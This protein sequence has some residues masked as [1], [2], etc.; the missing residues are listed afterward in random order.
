M[1]TSVKESPAPVAQAGSGSRRNDNWLFW[2]QLWI[3]L[4][5]GVATLVFWLLLP[6]DH[7]I[8]FSERSWRSI[9]PSFLDF[10]QISPVSALPF[11]VNSVMYVSLFATVI[12]ILVGTWQ[13]LN[14]AKSTRSDDAESRWAYKLTLLSLGLVSVWAI[15]ILTTDKR[16][17]F[18]EK[19]GIE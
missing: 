8:P 14:E 18:I 9:I 13:F 17:W 4:P 6:C 12:L 3:W 15:S 5:Q 7:V 11:L 10:S 16:L 1:T 2:K 19:W